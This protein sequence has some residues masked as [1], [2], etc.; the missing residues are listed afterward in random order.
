MTVP[1]FPEF[2]RAAAGPAWDLFDDA[3]RRTR[4]RAAKRAWLDQQLGAAGP[5]VRDFGAWIRAQPEQVQDLALGPRR[6]RQL[7]AGELA[8][9]RYTDPPGP[10]LTLEQLAATVPEP[11]PMSGLDPDDSNPDNP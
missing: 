10:P 8:V 7:R 9:D 4:V 5:P 1:N 6:A 2:A 3:E 11:F